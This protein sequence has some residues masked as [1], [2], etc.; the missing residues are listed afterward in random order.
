M[1]LSKPPKMHLPL[2][3][4]IKKHQKDNYIKIKFKRRIKSANLLPVPALLPNDIPEGRAH[5]LSLSLCVC[6]CLAGGRE[7]RRCDLG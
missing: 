3:N 1:K 7:M 2:E 6:V 5:A 4:K